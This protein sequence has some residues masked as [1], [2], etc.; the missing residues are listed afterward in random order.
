M[1][2]QTSIPLLSPFQSPI[3]S[4]MPSLESVSSFTSSTY[5]VSESSESSE[6]DYFLFSPTIIYR[7]ALPLNFIPPQ[8]DF[9]FLLSDWYF[10]ITKN[11]STD[12]PLLPPLYS[13]FL[14]AI[15]PSPIANVRIK[16]PSSLFTH[17]SLP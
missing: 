7:Y 10:E 6:I 11:I 4:S 1:Q 5:N 2:N 13:F 12:E 3:H 9:S 14:V 8:P 17:I 16:L 15:N